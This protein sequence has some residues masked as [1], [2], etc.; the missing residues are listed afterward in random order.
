MILNTHREQLKKQNRQEKLI[1]APMKIS[2]KTTYHS[3]REKSSPRD[4]LEVL[5]E[6]VKSVKVSGDTLSRS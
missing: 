6:S 3:D 4:V 2:L 1:Q 5:W